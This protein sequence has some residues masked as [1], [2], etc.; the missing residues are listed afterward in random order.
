MLLSFNYSP[1]GITVIT[2][3]AW[4]RKKNSPKAVRIR[5]RKF[6]PVCVLSMT[7][8]FRDFNLKKHQRKFVSTYVL[9]DD[10]LCSVLI[11]KTSASLSRCVS[12]NARNWPSRAE[13]KSERLRMRED[14]ISRKVASFNLQSDYCRAISC[15]ILQTFHERSWRFSRPRRSMSPRLRSTRK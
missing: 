2:R 5:L 4:R 7:I 8:L 6:V 1:R 11:L 9:D 15:A 12:R 13:K 3:D 10:T 14:F